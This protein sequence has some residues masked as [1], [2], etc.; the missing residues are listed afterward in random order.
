MSVRCSPAGSSVVA[1]PLDSSVNA[2]RALVAE[3]WRRYQGALEANREVDWARYGE[4][5]RRLGEA[6]ERL[7]ALEPFVASARRALNG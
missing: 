3:A 6:L 5:F 1:N 4:E 2:I 7:W